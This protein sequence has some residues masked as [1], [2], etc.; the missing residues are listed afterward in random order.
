M[1]RKILVLM[2]L[3]FTAVFMCFG[4]ESEDENWFWN[5]PITKIEFE[6]LKNVKKSDLNGV[7]SSFIDKPFTEDVYGELIDRLYA[8]DFFEDIVPYAK[9]ASKNDSNVLV[10]FQV[11]EMPEIKDIDFAG[12][13]KLRNSELRD[14]IKIKSTDLY[15]ESKV[16]MA[17][18]AIRNYYLEKGY[19]D[20][21]VKHEK[22]ETDDGSVRIIFNIEEGYN[23]IIK[24]IHISG[25]TLFSE[26]MIKSKFALKEAGFLKDGAFQSSL[27]EQDKQTLA[28]YY[29]ERGYIDVNILDVTIDK[30]YN[31]EKNQQELHITYYIQEGA[32]YVYTGIEY[33]GNEVFSKKELRDCEKLKPGSIYNDVKFQATIM[34]IATLYMNNG[35]MS[36]NFAP[37]PNK[38][39]ERHEIS[40]SLSI[41]ENSRAHV[42]NIIIKG[43]NKTKEFVVKREI[44]INSGDVYSRDKIISAY[45]NLMNLQYFSNVVPEPQQGSEQDL[46]DIVFNVE[47][48]S[49]TSLQLGMT[50][51]EAIDPT[52]LPISLFFKFE[53]SNLFG[54][55]RTISSSLSLSTSTQSIDLSYSQ[56]WVGKIPLTF[57]SSL[58]F[59]HTDSV[60]PVNMWL[61]NGTFNQKLYYMNFEGFSASLGNGLSRRWY[62]DYA[63][64]SAGAGMSNSLT[65]NIYNESLYVP[66]DYSISYY[67]N[68]WGLSNSVSLQGSVDNRDINYEPTKGWFASERLSWTGLIPGL[69]KDFFLKSDT[70]LEGYLKLCDVPMFNE[71]W[72]FRL[73]LAGY[74]GFTG[75]F[76]ASGTAISDS[77][78]VY[79]DGML[80]GRGWTDIYK[81]SKGLALFSNRLELRMPIVPNILGI[82]GFFDACAVKPSVSSVFNS[83]SVDDFYFSFGPGVRFLIPQ[84]PLHLLFAWRFTSKGFDKTPFQFV[85]S[86]NIV[87]R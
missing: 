72:N 69:E 43:N 61:P 7:I 21:K 16:L 36:A 4:Q 32:Q 5:Q 79:V 13:R 53:N 59:S 48:Q 64:I 54:E 65:N 78:K 18:R 14:K 46:V 73:V 47:E 37:V 76:P 85:L 75:L 52:A 87:N 84:F 8:M 11:K 45:R 19:T 80:N 67:A 20:S 68:R 70:K 22:I 71:K 12:N 86:F 26:R 34:D 39:S 42:E 9:H 28:S 27:L 74:T 66:V 55:G 63:I 38:D 58:S 81:T 51:A 15:S 23:T 10:V 60:T 31:E 24:Q 56:N 33:Y 35:Y 82:D 62:T 40:Y 29:K 2:L 50:F 17:E 44:P 83:L 49:T 25:N 3:I 57:S 77:N 1:Q 30:I 41:I 6:G